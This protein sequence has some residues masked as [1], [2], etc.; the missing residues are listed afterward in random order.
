MHLIPV[1][2]FPLLSG[3][4]SFC[5]AKIPI[6][7]LSYELCIGFLFTILYLLFTIVNLPQLLFVYVV[8][9]ISLPILLIDSK[10]HIIPDE[11]V[12]LLIIAGLLLN[13]AHIPQLIGSA[14]LTTFIMWVPYYVTVG[15]GM[16]MG[17]VKLAFGIGAILPF[18]YAFSALY[19]AFL[20]GGLI[21]VI[22]IVM[23]KKSLKSAIPFGPFMVLG[24][25]CVLIYYLKT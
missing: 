14:V 19:I 1:V 11:L 18:A 4:C 21:S 20:T 3:R 2:S 9:T 6:S 23:R 12:F 7:H 13:S 24:L 10:E 22:L 15:K 8:L 16:G 17:D 25:V 5:K